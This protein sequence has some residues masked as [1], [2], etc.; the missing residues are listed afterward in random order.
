MWNLRF[1]ASIDA[2]PAAQ[3]NRIAATDYPFVR[4][5]FLQALEHSGATSAA[6]GWQVA[7]AVV[8][9]HGVPVA[10][11]PLYRKGHSYGE[12]VFDH[13]WAGAY[14]RHGMEY[15]PKLVAAIPFTPVT[16]PRLCVADGVNEATVLRHLVDGIGTLLDEGGG[17]SWHVLFPQE[18]LT[19]SLMDSGLLLRRGVQF[20]WHN[21]G[22]RDF[23][24][25]LERFSSRKRKAVRRERA[26][27]AEQGLT[28]TTYSGA[29]ITSEHWDHFF[30]FYQLTYAKRSGHGGYLNRSFF[31]RLGTVMADQLVLVMARHDGREVG[32]ALS[33]R[34]QHNL[35]GRYWGCTREFDNLHFEACYYRG[36]EYC[37]EHGLSRFDSGAQGEHKIQRGFE[38]CDTWSCHWIAHPGFRQAIERFLVEDGAE[39]ERYRQAA[40]ELLPFKR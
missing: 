22:Y 19:R 21:R 3:W 1:I 29:E 6:T 12:Y 4:H 40:R 18:A 23:D 34:D 28:L 24:D 32:G 33:L 26:R 20:H 15:Y 8:Y 30:T 35:Y 9:R 38:P 27:V 13:A 10:F 16:G 14:H 36:I 2:V 31:E 7:H 17:S 11:M 39:V 37:I 25:F 5:E